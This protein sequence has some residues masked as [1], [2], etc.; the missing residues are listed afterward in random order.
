MS[1]AEDLSRHYASV[2]RRLNQPPPKVV[3]IVVPPPVDGDV[4]DIPA[5]LPVRRQLPPPTSRDVQIAVSRH[6]HVSI[7]EMVSQRRARSVTFPRQVAMYL[8]KVL[9]NQSY[10]QIGGRF[11]GRD[12][13]TVMHAFDKIANLVEQDEPT[14]LVVAKIKARIMEGRE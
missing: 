9:T 7:A 6:F 3:R 2:R 12:H 14:A 8:T 10:P 1:V 4:I 13:T 11:G 5:F